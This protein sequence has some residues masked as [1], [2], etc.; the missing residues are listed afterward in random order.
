MLPP[1]VVDEEL[2]AL[3]QQAAEMTA[4]EP[5][6]TRVRL[7]SRL[8][9]AL[10]F[11]DRRDRMA[12]LSAE[13][14]EIAA[15]LGDPEAIALAAAARRRAY[16]GPGHL[17]R[18][19][20]DSTQLLRA[21]R[22]AA[23]IELTLQGHA[24]LVVDLLERGDRT[25]V[26]TQI[27][28]FTAGAERL[29]QPLFLWNAAV[30]QAMQALL[31][32]R[33]DE[34]ETLAGGGA[35]LGDPARG[36]DRA[37]V[38]RDPDARRAPRAGP[39]WASWRTRSREALVGQPRRGR[40]ARRAG[41]AAVRDGPPEEARDRARARCAQDFADIPLD[42]DWLVTV[43]LL[44]DASRARRR[45]RAAVALRAAAPLA[46]TNVVIGLAAVCLGSTAR[47]LGR[48]ALT[49]GRREDAARHLRHAMR[50]QRVAAGPGEAGPRPAGPAPLRWAPAARRASCSSGAE[51]ARAAA[52]TGGGPPRRRAART[53]ASA[54]RSRSCACTVQRR[55][56]RALPC[57]TM[58]KTLVIAEKPSVGRDLVRVLPGAF[59]RSGKGYL[60]GPDHVVTWAVGH[61]VQLADPDEYDDQ[62][63]KWRMADLPIVPEQFKL[64]VRDE[65]SKKQMN[66]VKRMLGRDDVETRR[67]RLRRRARGRADLRLPV[68]EGGLATSRCSGC[69]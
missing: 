14:T 25:G 28:A 6:V 66:V 69:G 53:I 16:W 12:R 3:L 57:P 13:A 22:E 19:L 11:S 68:R 64:V 1:G 43:T 30:W 44:A 10:Y 47:Y 32:G 65:R 21:A 5:T 41:H 61:L 51:A 67:Q 55:L 46:D 29:R 58:A 4:D 52:A 24:W 39:A 50:G 35:V 7:L 17:E 40:V 38:L 45:G 56:H 2:I 20:A 63:K 27:E 34:A 33:L 8:C 15:E 31:D 18:R 62:Y 36:R 59:T 23:D 9:G 49:L 42:G 54:A 48:L 60:E 26:E 37:P